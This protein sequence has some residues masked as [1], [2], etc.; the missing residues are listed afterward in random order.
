MGG[1]QWTVTSPNADIAEYLCH[2]PGGAQ[3]HQFLR[4]D[5]LFFFYYIY[6]CNNHYCYLIV[7]DSTMRLV[8]RKAKEK[9]AQRLRMMRPKIRSNPSKEK[10][11]NPVSFDMFLYLIYVDLFDCWL[12]LF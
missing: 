2:I 4:Y 9:V 12:F 5:F 10:K 7:K 1:Q 6:R 11:T 8:I 3:L